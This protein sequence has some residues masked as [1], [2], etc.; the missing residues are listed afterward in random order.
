MSFIHIKNV[1]L[2]GLSTCVPNQVVKN[3]NDIIQPVNYDAKS[4]VKST[5]VATR[6]LSDKLTTSDLCFKA[7][8]KLISELGW[9]RNSID[10]LIF[11]SQSPDYLLPATACILQDRLKLSKECF[12][13]DISMGCSGWVYGL[14]TIS[15]L[16]ASGDM[17]RGLLLV[18]DAKKQYPAD[19]PLFG[20]AGSA[21]A[22]EY[23]EGNKGFYFHFGTDGKG[24]D[25][26]I[27][28]EG[29]SRM[30]LSPSSFRT[31]KINGKNYSRLETRMKGMEVF[32]FATSTAPQSIKKLCKRY[33]LDSE[34]IDYL[35]LHQSN[36]KMLNL[37]KNLLHLSDEKV[38]ICLDEYG[39][40]SSASIPMTIV[41]R[42][43]KKL[44]R[45][46]HSIICSGFGVGLSWGSVWMQVEN[47]VLPDVLT[48]NDDEADTAH[49]A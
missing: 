13:E 9:E 17:K 26:I 48:M 14:S 8:E 2:K 29:G 38:P 31:E 44:N 37:I 39:N 21:T 27:L 32:L 34:S 49:L 11:V 16:I 28:P 25:N 15:S 18:G 10:A 12:C 33:C 35:V 20:Y 4:F 42:L 6:H 47:L 3:T 43:N 7:S 40:T 46:S 24:Y 41:S 30:G 19:D 5:G 45:E 36:L 23:D 1:K 22:I